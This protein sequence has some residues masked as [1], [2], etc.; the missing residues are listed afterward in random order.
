LATGGL[1]EMGKGLWS[2]S[3]YSSKFL[4]FGNVVTQG[5]EGQGLVFL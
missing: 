3:A 5:V 2:A 4:G 1:L